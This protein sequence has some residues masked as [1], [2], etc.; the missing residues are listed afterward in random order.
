M[1]FQKKETPVGIIPKFV[2]ARKQRSAIPDGVKF[3]TRLFVIAALGNFIL[4]FIFFSGLKLN[5]ASS[6]A[7][8]DEVAG[9]YQGSG[10]EDPLITKVPGLADVLDGPIING[11]DPSLGPE[12]APV[13]ITYFADYECR[14]CQKQEVVIKKAVEKHKDK[15][16]LVWKDY[17]ERDAA[18]GSF[19][20]AVA[21][22]CAQE[23]GQFWPFHDLLFKNS[24]ELSK[25]LFIALAEKLNL[26]KS[27][28]SGCLR[29]NE[30]S[31]L[32]KSNILEAE[33]LDIKG[34]PFIF[35]NQREVMG[36]ATEEDL[37]KIIDIEL[38]EL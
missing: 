20:A 7:G 29:D 27:L 32:V 31:Q 35:I 38:D 3:P 37:N 26:R 13:V 6:Q 1:S 25:D 10:T 22:R 8:S 34:V 14:Y 9:I 4:L 36:E 28:F 33:A 11:S 24:E 30:I 16:R 12:E 17:P 18:S 2:P 23:Q 15:I 21:G 5:L 19:S